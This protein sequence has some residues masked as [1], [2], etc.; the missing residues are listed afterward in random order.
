MSGSAI[1]DFRSKRPYMETVV[2]RIKENLEILVANKIGEKLDHAIKTIQ[3]Q[4]DRLVG[5][6]TK[7]TDSM[8]VL[9]NKVDHI[10]KKVDTLLNTNQDGN[11]QESGAGKKRKL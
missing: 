8:V 10:N 3:D 4:D 11:Q 9:H 5:K 7:I 1:E 6:V 2:S